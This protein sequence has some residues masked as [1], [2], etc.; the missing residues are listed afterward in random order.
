MIVEMVTCDH[1]DTTE[2]MDHSLV[3]DT[4]WTGDGKHYCTRACAARAWGV[5]G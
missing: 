3:P 1:C 5:M 4:W 2:I